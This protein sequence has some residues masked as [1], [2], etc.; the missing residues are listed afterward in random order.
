M[1]DVIVLGAGIVGVTTALA[2]QERGHS[3]TIVDHGQ[4]E[5]RSS[6]GNAGIIQAEAA[7][8]YAMPRSV[9]ELLSI[10]LGRSNAVRWRWSALPTHLL[11]LLAY[12]RN[13]APSR[14]RQISRTY[15]QLTSRATRDHARLIEA[16]GA[17]SLIRQDGF[18]HGYR[19]N[20]SF[21]TAADRAERLERDYGVRHLL[22]G[23]LALS[24]AEPNLLV[25]MAGAIH[26]T[27]SWTC[28]DPGRL[29]AAYRS[30]FESRGGRVTAGDAM[31][32]ERRGKSWSVPVGPGGDP[33]DA[34]DA[35]I[36]IGDRS[37]ELGRR[38]GLKIPL[39]RKRGYH[40]HFKPRAGPDLLLV[41]VANSSVLAPMAQGLRILT[42]AEI[43]LRPAEAEAVQL[44]RATRGARELFDIGAPLEATAW[45]GSRPCMPDM[46]PVTGAFPAQQGLWANFGHGHQGFTLGP[47]TAD[48]L[49]NL[50]TGE[51]PSD[52]SLS[53]DRFPASY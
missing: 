16:A 15:V 11:P 12:F 7:E 30:L 1:R 33:V 28:S 31:A 36:A 3:V 41:D 23:S 27:D 25:P 50:M 20:E 21:D 44:D 48:L 8:P 29:L 52:P 9:R 40:R 39:F 32:L 45:A 10:A 53:P 26:W 17:W 38:F 34:S 22:L 37:A 19:D 42:G 14:H 24:R 5:S 35:V 51:Y 13:S 49:A 46:L 6:Y 43:A 2:L 47:T 18:R 4:P